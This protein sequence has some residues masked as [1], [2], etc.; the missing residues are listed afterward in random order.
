MSYNA[1]RIHKAEHNVYEVRDYFECYNVVQLER[2]VKLL[3]R[4][5]VARRARAG[6]LRAALE[7][8]SRSRSGACGQPSHVKRAN[9]DASERAWLTL[10]LKQLNRCNLCMEFMRMLLGKLTSS[11]VDATSPV[12]AQ[13]IRYYRKKINVPERISDTLTIDRQV[14]YGRR[15]AAGVDH[16]VVRDM[17]DGDEDR[18]RTLS[19]QGAPKE[20]RNVVCGGIYHDIDMEN[21]FPNIAIFLGQR[22][23]Y[24]F[25]VLT[26]YTESKASREALLK[27]IVDK[28]RLDH[29]FPDPSEARDR[30]KRLPLT[31]LHGG[32]YYGW[33]K[34]WN[35]PCEE[36]VESMRQLADEMIQLNR[37]AAASKRTIEKTIYGNRAAFQ[38][39]TGKSDDPVSHGK[40][41]NQLERSLIATVLQT[42]ENRIL[43]IIVEFADA[44]GWVV[45][46]L[47]FDGLFIE[48]RDDGSLHDFMRA[49][50]KRIAECMM[51]P[52]GK[53]LAI[54]LE[55]KDLFHKRA[56][57][58]L[59]EW[60]EL[61]NQQLVRVRR[62]LTCRDTN[63]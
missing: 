57:P 37:G 22:Y 1:R 51:E 60:S 2:A 20:V 38:R 30:A 45:G 44:Q 10:Q 62:A 31:L 40:R 27:E 4:G 7:L 29:H 36:L 24:T 34:T 46:S 52:D 14:Q 59:R 49:A 54:R 11:D 23:G 35:L 42:Y 43:E 19:L 50:E 56:D 47:Q 15:I 5:A 28:H 13:R 63:L 26:R 8:A 58:I 21:C 3:A 33:T 41:L 55:E 6:E 9:T 12:R 16:L 25:P 53:T 39:L 48:H 17:T 18:V 61:P 32:T